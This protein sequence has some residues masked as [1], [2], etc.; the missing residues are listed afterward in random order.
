[1][2]HF[3]KIT[4]TDNEK[5]WMGIP[6]C[7]CVCSYMYIDCNCAG[8]HGIVRKLVFAHSMPFGY[9]QYIVATNDIIIDVFAS[10]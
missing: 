6:E 5:K 4:K 10:V 3:Y 1:M 7:D 8:H 9:N 2:G